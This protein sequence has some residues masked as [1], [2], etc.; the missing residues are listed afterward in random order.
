MSTA[1]VVALIALFGTIVS[2]LLTVYGASI[3]KARR[4][5]S[6][7]AKKVLE[8][9][10]QPLL[11]AAFELQARLYNILQLH[12]VEKYIIGNQADQRDTAMSSTLYVFAQFF[13]VQEIIRQEVQDSHFSRDRQ[14]REIGMVL[15]DINETF[16]TD[17]YGPQFMIWRIGQRGLGERMIVT[18][19]G[20]M[21]CIGYS[22][23]LERYPTM[24]EWLEPFLHALEHLGDGG[25]KRLMELQHLLIELVRRLDE[26]Q[27]SYPFELKKA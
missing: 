5:A 11:S 12:F 8:D 16:L 4:R 18:S 26:K 14:T 1:V 9:Y 17:R 22:T 27:K 25:R 10:R 2:A 20:N 3:L 7:N 13:G 19:D 24:Q 21:S 6:R 23:F 15:R